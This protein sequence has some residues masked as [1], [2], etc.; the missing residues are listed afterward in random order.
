L[1][2]FSYFENFAIKKA[3]RGAAGLLKARARGRYRYPTPRHGNVVD[4]VY[5]MDT[6]KAGNTVVGGI[7]VPL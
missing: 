5:L 6:K 3:I 1:F 2:L 7:F 4:I